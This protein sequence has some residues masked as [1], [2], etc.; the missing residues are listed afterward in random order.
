MKGQR[1]QANRG[2][3]PHARAVLQ[4]APSHRRS[5]SHFDSRGT[6]ASAWGRQGP[7]EIST[8]QAHPR[9]E[10]L[11]NRLGPTLPCPKAR[12]RVGCFIVGS[13]WTRGRERDA[14]EKGKKWVKGQNSAVSLLHACLSFRNN[15]CS[16]SNCDCAPECLASSSTWNT[17]ERARNCSQLAAAVAAGRAAAQAWSPQNCPWGQSA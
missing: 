6:Q 9:A 8:T 17:G 16:L 13:G 3:Q 15:L 14:D 2:S 7:T 12:G 4:E 1:P 11:Q 5:Q 10:P